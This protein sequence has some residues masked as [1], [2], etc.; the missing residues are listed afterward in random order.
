MQEF[1]NPT[2]PFE[3]QYAPSWDTSQGS[4]DPK[5]IMVDKMKEEFDKTL[6]D[7]GTNNPRELFNTYY[8]KSYLYDMDEIV[9]ALIYMYTE[10]QKKY[11]SVKK[12]KVESCPGYQLARIDKLSTKTV[13]RPPP[14]DLNDVRRSYTPIFWA[15]VYFQIRTSEEQLKINKVKY[16]KIS[17]EV[18]Y[19]YYREKKELIYVK[20]EPI[21]GTEI[22]VTKHSHGYLQS[23]HLAD[24]GLAVK[25]LFD[26]NL[27]LWY[28]KE[29]IKG[30]PKMLY[31]L[32]LSELTK[33]NTMIRGRAF[34]EFMD[35]DET[36]YSGGPQADPPGI[37]D[38]PA[39]FEG[40]GLSGIGGAGAGDASPDYFDL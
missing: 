30:F 40:S 13:T 1:M 8:K 34:G 18:S 36:L 2:N 29:A 6:L 17:E 19:I 14:P 35:L 10:F 38:P 26:K 16:N 31:R 25:K 37:G 23:Q 32:N 27:H 11:P 39:D 3:P 24:A 7:Y 5:K 12:V 15:Q 9:S 33:Q 28:I 22:E 21:T 4:R 20:T